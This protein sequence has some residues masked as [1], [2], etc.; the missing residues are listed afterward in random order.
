MLKNCFVTSELAPLAKVGGLADV[1][2]ALPLALAKLGHDVRV[3][4]PYYRDF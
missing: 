4:V 2:Q 3:I 1:S